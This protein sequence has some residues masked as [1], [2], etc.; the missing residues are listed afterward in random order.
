MSPRSPLLRLAAL[1]AIWVWTAA[2]PQTAPPSAEQTQAQSGYIIGPGDTLQVF[3]WREPGLSTTLPVRPDGRITT[4]LVED[5]VAVGKTPSQL[6]RDVEKVL[7]KYI[8]SPQ[9]NILVSQPMS[10]FS[11][12]QIIGQVAKPQSIPYREGMKVLDAVLA[13]GGLAPYAAG[14]RAKLIRKTNGKQQEMRVKLADLVDKGDLSQNLDMKP[15]DVLVI[16]ESMF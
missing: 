7:S 8:K 9:V 12:V 10:T 14:N 16:P 4:P 13:S 15:G 2:W 11:Q 5:M 1:A 6:A 3:V